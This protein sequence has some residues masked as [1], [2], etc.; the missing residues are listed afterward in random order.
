MARLD[1]LASIALFGLGIACVVIMVLSM[2]SS[3][4]Y[5]IVSMAFAMLV[6]TWALWASGLYDMPGGNLDYRL[7]RSGGEALRQAGAFFIGAFIAALLP[8]SWICHRW[9][10][11]KPVWKDVVFGK[12][13]KCGYDVRGNPSGI[14]SE[15]GT[16]F[17]KSATIQ[18]DSS[19]QSASGH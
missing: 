14:C 6:G 10:Q 3:R 13:R 16:A 7:P 9:I 19:D 17:R 12:C 2:R 5:M 8:G 4:R 15:C 1:H 11:G 18:T